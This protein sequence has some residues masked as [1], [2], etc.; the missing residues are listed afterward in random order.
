VSG[1]D[2]DL[3][4]LV[5]RL[6]P[7]D[8]RDGRDGHHGRDGAD[9]QPGERG[10]PGPL[11]LHDWQGSTLRFE[12]SHGVWGESVDLRGER[13]ERGQ[14]GQ[15]GRH[16]VDGKDGA[17]GAPGA[18]GSR[19]ERGKQG[20]IGPRGPI[21]PMP[22]HEWD[23]TALRFEIA[24][25]IWG[26]FVDLQGPP[27][28][29][30]RGGGG[31]FGMGQSVDLSGYLKADGTVPLTGDWDSGAHKITAGDLAGFTLQLTGTSM[32]PTHT[33]GG[34]TVQSKV[35]IPSLTLGTYEQTVA[36]GIAAAS[37]PTARVLSLFDARTVSHQP[38]L[39]VFDPSESQVV[40]F[41]WEGS[42]SDAYI[43]F[44][45]D[46]LSLKRGT[47][48]LTA[49]D[50]LVQ[51]YKPL[52]L[53]ADPVAA[54]E[55]AT[56]QYVDAVAAG[57]PG[58]VN[59]I[60]SGS[61]APSGAVG[62]DGDFY[63]DTTA[64]AIYGPKTAGVWGSPTSLTGPQGPQGDPGATG[65]TGA[66]GPAGATGPQ[67]DPGA[68]GATGPTGPTGATG[69]AGVPGSVWRDGTGAPSNSLGIN[70][71]YYLDDA[72]GNVYLKSSGAYAIVGNIK[73]ATGATGSTGSTGATGPAG[74]TGATG[75]AGPAGAYKNA[76]M[77]GAFDVWQRGIS[78]TGV[79][80]SAYVA[81]RWQFA[82]SSGGTWAVQQ[83]ANVPSVAQAGL[84]V[85]S[86][87]LMAPTV[88]QVSLGSSALIALLQKI[89]GYDWRWFAQRELTLSF[90]VYAPLT[91]TFC[92]SLR[93][94]APDRSYVAEYTVN[95]INTWEKKT[96]TIPASP[97]AGTWNYTNGIGLYL[98]FCLGAGSTFQTT[99]NAWQTGNFLCTS[100]QTN[101]AA[102]TSNY[103]DIALVQLEAG[104]V[105][106]DFNVAPFEAEYARCLRYYEK[107]F[108]YATVPAQAA[109]GSSALWF[110]QAVAASTTA[111]IGGTKFEVYKRA[112]PTITLYN[113]QATNAQARN[114]TTNTDCSAT[115]VVVSSE[116]GFALNATSPSGSAVGQGLY[117]NFV[118]DAEL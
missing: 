20:E 48:I 62:A 44:T 56:K 37:D 36:M 107:S 118:A 106:T 105:A 23:G 53:N 6:K 4:Q 115:S 99:A 63:I 87:L 64:D 109:G 39:S 24:P 22:R 73:G 77:N 52:L 117:I 34:A 113:P 18:R 65:A 59:T 33:P 81:D 68:T 91:G 16:G 40:G 76:V 43:K 7:R 112:T 11:P 42:S 110:T 58:A 8:G 89:E 54:L 60:L 98:A 15:N 72:T 38:T 102:S 14:D 46:T 47:V 5:A 29:A 88:A 12:K 104:P 9:G 83:N 100:N 82:I 55:A 41:S 66:T 13:G 67:G 3:E 50:S 93:N 26:M 95:A 57:G 108:P 69:S 97:S 19:G 51:A 2:V 74:A 10:L 61:G 92:V 27:G 114:A 75:P 31:G 85:P 25:D 17:D 96:I 94:A 71:D 90:W 116:N 70:G 86:C 80:A 103:L 30:G 32:I 78:F 28:P 1:R 79:T 111:M 21:G 45:G 84:V 49:S 101:V 35:D